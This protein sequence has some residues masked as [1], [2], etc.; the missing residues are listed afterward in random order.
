MREGEEGYE[1]Y[2]ANRLVKKK[3]VR[4]V[5][6]P[7]DL[8]M[9]S[10]YAPDNRALSNDDHDTSHIRKVVVPASPLMYQRFYDWPPENEYARVKAEPPP[11]NDVD[12]AN[13]MMTQSSSFGGGRSIDTERSRRLL[14]QPRS[15]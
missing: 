2:D 4:Q 5:V 11:K 7:E 3:K 14:G 12:C 6:E 9:F 15:L 8:P 10:M 13:E 1:P